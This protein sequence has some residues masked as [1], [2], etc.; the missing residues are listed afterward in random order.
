MISSHGD[1][2]TVISSHGDLVTS[3]LVTEKICSI[4]FFVQY[5]IDFQLTGNYTA[6]DKK[7]KLF[8]FRCRGERQ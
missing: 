2:V 1:F 3:D 8:T 4:F 7:L 5:F 6:V